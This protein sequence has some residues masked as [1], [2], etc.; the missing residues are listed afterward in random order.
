MLLVIIDVHSKWIDVH[1]TNASTSQ[2]TI[3]K[4][5]QTFAT[6]AYQTLLSLTMEQA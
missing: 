5:M 6:H 2:A 1:V 3:E 4:L